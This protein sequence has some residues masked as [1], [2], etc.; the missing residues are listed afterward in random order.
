LKVLVVEMGDFGNEY[1]A[2]LQIL[3][4]LI[5]TIILGLP[6]FGYAYNKLLDAL[7][8]KEHTSVY[9]AG[10]VL[11]TLAAGALISWKSALLFTVLF[12]LDGIF[13]IVGEFKR[14]EKQAKA[15]RRKRMP[16][17]ANG[18]LDEAKMSA[19]ELHKHIG[20][21]LESSDPKKINLMQVE[22]TTILLKLT[23]LKSIQD[24]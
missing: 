3:L 2:N 24:K 9:V 15:P 7:K 12:A 10:G 5:V 17:A 13:M 18:L 20:Q 6:V 14:T 19:T 23:E 21:Y 4:P 11:F 22:V 8:G 1:V 16:Y